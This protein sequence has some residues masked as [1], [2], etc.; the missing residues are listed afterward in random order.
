[1]GGCGD[2]KNWK[3]LRLLFGRE[4]LISVREQLL[5]GGRDEWNQSLL[6]N[7]VQL[8]E[9][10][11]VRYSIKSHLSYLLGCLLNIFRNVVLDFIRQRFQH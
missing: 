3:P 1:M 9:Y 11:F 10:H 7:E 4:L 5:D 8:G 2:Y 6:S